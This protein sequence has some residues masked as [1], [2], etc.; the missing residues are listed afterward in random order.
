[1]K[2]VLCHE[3][4]PVETLTF[5]EIGAPSA[6]PGQV[7]IDV[8]ACGVQ[9]VDNR[10]IE[11]NSLLNTSQLNDHF[12]RDMRISFPLVPGSE[13]AGVVADVGEGV[14]RFKK[15]DRVLATSIVGCWAEQALFDE[16][17]VALIPDNM[18]FDTAACF[19]V[20]NFTAYYSVVERGALQA[21]ETVLVLGAGSGV[22]L[23][24]IDIVKAMGGRVIAAASSAEKLALAKEHGADDV[25]N[26]GIAP[27][28]RDQQKALTA[29]FKKA[30]GSAGIQLIADLVGGDYA[31]PA[32]RAM[33]FKGRYLSVGFSAGVPSIPMSVIF[34]K[35]GCIIGI[36]PVTDKRLPGEKPDMMAQ[37]Y[38]WFE[39][40]KIRPLITE[41]Y[42]PEKA[43]LAL[44]KLAERKA[45]GRI[46][47]ELRGAR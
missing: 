28:G 43:V 18:G 22:G 26:Y 5:G 42:P 39:D 35:N 38:R 25:I 1:M 45:A 13:A 33:A 10:I 14:T 15:G 20:A 27:L 40:G 7:L 34:N 37:L 21:G 17:E 3:F 47:L 23:A 2:A 11:G 6:G 46:I 12:G 29:A 44:K 19:Y 41:R 30:G 32:M 8:H 4:G 24:T 36:E 16:D 31:Q 9:F